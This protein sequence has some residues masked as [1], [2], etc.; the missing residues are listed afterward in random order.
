M[1]KKKA[2][3]RRTTASRTRARKPATPARAASLHASP[4]VTLN[5]TVT[6]TAVPPLAKGEAYAGILLK[7]DGTPSHHV[8]LLPSEAEDVTWQD[9][10]AFAAKTGGELPTR[11]EQALLFANASQHFKPRWYWSGEELAG[12]AEYAWFQ[13]FS[14]GYQI[15]WHK[16]SKSRARA[17]RRVPI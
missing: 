14:S 15:T 3:L 9:A 1:A 4:Q 11:K 2:A 16:S 10:K 12:N 5:A 7:E 6:T 17:V 13:F 8:V